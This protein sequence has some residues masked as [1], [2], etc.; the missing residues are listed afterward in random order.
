MIDIV[1]QICSE[2]VLFLYATAIL[3]DGAPSPLPPVPLP[4]CVAAL[5]SYSALNFPRS[6]SLLFLYSAPFWGSQLG[7]EALNGAGYSASDLIPIDFD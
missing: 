2:T 5:Y 3:R 6:A 7:S 4:F 1:F